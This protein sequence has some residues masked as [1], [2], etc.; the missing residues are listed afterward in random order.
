[1][2]RR[3]HTPTDASFPRYGGRGIVVC[4]RWRESFEAFLADVGLR[5]SPTHSI[6][7]I[8]SEG[9]YEPGNV[10]WATPLQQGKN[11]SRNINHDV[12]GKTQNLSQLSTQ[13]GG[14]RNLVR[15]RLKRGWT[16]ERAVTEPVHR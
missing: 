1:M 16:L 10:R 2:K 9:N 12:D 5:P 14:R 11:T 8:K 4:A 7:R 15:K 3:C 6:D 13:L